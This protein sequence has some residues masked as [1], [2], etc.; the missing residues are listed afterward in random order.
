MFAKVKG[1]KEKYMIKTVAK[2]Q[3]YEGTKIEPFC[4]S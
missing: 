2:D 1:N 4:K 3:G